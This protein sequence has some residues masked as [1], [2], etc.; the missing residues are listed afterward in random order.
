MGGSWIRSW[1]KLLVNIHCFNSKQAIRVKKCLLSACNG[2]PIVR[3]RYRKAK[4][5]GLYFFFNSSC[6]PKTLHPHS[7]LLF[8]WVSLFI[9]ATYIAMFWFDKIR[10]DKTPG[11][12]TKM[13]KFKIVKPFKGADGRPSKNR[14]Y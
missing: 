11:I 8:L 5:N 12:P 4:K 10:F 1:C 14:Y 7:L 6:A 3:S 9:R 2:K 13:A